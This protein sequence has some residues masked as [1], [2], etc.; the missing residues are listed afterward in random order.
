MVSDTNQST[1]R[2][3]DTR[4]RGKHKSP[5]VSVVVS[6][7]A[8]ER[9]QSL[10][11]QGGFSVSDTI[12]CCIDHCLPALEKKYQSPTPRRDKEAPQ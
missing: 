4:R 2:V 11:E 3:S 10:A 7:T 8:F 1:N 5:R 6:D 9:L 12:R